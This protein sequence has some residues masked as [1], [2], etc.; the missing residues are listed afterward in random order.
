[1]APLLES[2]LA[3]DRSPSDR[4]R[5]RVREAPRTRAATE[6]VRAA[7]RSFRPSF[8]GSSGKAIGDY[9]MIEDGDRVM[10]CLSGRQGLLHAARHAA[11]ACSAKPP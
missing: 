1:M 6:A 5:R 8:A 7:G 11:V 3:L 2:A 4:H 9:R 10:V